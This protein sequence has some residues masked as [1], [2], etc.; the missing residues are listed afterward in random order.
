MLSVGLGFTEHRQFG[1]ETYLGKGENTLSSEEC[2]GGSFDKRGSHD[3][4]QQ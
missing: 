2:K 3:V 1:T 4:L